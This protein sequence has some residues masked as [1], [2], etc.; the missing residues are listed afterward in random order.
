MSAREEIL[1][2]INKNKAALIPLSLD[3][4]KS[5]NERVDLIDAFTNVLNSIGGEAEIVKDYRAVETHL[6][7]ITA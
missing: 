2:L 3:E 7:M 5:E 1:G 6:A 4:I